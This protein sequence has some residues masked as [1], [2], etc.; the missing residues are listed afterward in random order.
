VSLAEAAIASGRIPLSPSTSPNVKRH[1]LPSTASI[2]PQHGS[3]SATAL[4]GNMADVKDTRICELRVQV[5]E[6]RKELQSAQD[7]QQ[8]E[9]KRAERLAV[10]LSEYRDEAEHLQAEVR[11]SCCY[12][13]ALRGKRACPR[14]RIWTYCRMNCTASESS[15]SCSCVLLRVKQRWHVA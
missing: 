7:A 5:S 9:C 4:L 3:D 11:S 8:Q 15:C 13:A 2:L 14:K 1:T 6:S 12:A 10:E